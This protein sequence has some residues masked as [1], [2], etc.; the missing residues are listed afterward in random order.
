MHILPIYRC[1]A[2]LWRE[3]E[4]ERERERVR[5]RERERIKRTFGFSLCFG[6]HPVKI[7]PVEGRPSLYLYNKTSKLYLE[8]SRHFGNWL[9]A[10]GGSGTE[11]AAKRQVKLVRFSGMN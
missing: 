4:S 8:K 3:S 6:E 7:K 10:G 2:C 5:E 9:R 1:L 11:A